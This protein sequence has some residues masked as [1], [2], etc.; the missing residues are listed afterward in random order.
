MG[1]SHLCGDA[2]YVVTHS[3]VGEGHFRMQRGFCEQLVSS[4]SR[5]GVIRTHSR[6]AYHA[7]DLSARH[8]L[9]G[10]RLEE[11]DNDVLQKWCELAKIVSNISLK[12]SFSGI[13]EHDT[14]GVRRHSPGAR[15]VHDA[16]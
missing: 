7:E 10:I 5:C 14:G 12:P 1:G 2:F 9:V 15:R 11:T 3:D 13:A 16:A 4:H 8:A 6:A